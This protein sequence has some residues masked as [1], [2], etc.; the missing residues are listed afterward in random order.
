MLIWAGFWIVASVVAFA[1]CAWLP[2]S[3]RMPA[4]PFLTADSDWPPNFLDTTRLSQTIALRFFAADPRFTTQI[5]ELQSCSAR[6]RQSSERY[7]PGTDSADQTGRS[8][9][10]RRLR[11]ATEE[12]IACRQ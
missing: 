1:A 5:G 8:F 10:L 7:K 9:S 12:G 6:N 4:Q 3:D 11:H 2:I